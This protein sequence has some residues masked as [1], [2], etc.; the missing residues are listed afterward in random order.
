MFFWQNWKIF[1]SCDIETGPQT[2]ELESPAR[3]KDSRQSR[4][5]STLLEGLF[6]SAPPSTAMHIT[7]NRLHPAASANFVSVLQSNEAEF[8]RVA[9]VAFFT[10]DFSLSLS[11]SLSLSGSVARDACEGQWRL[12]SPI[13]RSVSPF[14][15]ALP[16][17][18][19]VYQSASLRP[20]QMKSVDQMAADAVQCSTEVVMQ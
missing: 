19:L 10:A 3:S 16:P 15:S 13:V 18:L 7:T 5:C 9:A 14:Q 2:S 6:A 17:S 12:I 4:F 8:Q 1:L 20:S 11:L